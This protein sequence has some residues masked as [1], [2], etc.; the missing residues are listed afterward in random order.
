MFPSVNIDI[1][2]LG[3]PKNCEGATVIFK[4]C[5]QVKKNTVFGHFKKTLYKN[6]INESLKEY[7]SLGF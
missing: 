6:Y 1:P 2:K 7:L 3:L 4:Y 5:I